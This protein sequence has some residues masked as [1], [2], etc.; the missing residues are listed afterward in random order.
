MS[1]YT[2]AVEEGNVLRLGFGDTPAQND[3]LVKEAAQQLKELIDGGVIRGGGTDK[4]ERTG[5]V[6]DSF[7]SGAQAQSSLSGGCG[8]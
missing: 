3:A 6:T 4:A 2:L 7:C 1:I 8:L 5:N